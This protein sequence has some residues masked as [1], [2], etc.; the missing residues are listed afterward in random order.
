MLE[1]GTAAGVEDDDDHGRISI[2]NLLRCEALQLASAMTGQLKVTDKTLNFMFSF[3]KRTEKN[4]T[5]C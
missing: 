2:I 3:L 4:E 5:G 1:E